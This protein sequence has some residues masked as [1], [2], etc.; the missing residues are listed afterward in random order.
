M[1]IAEPD[2]ARFSNAVLEIIVETEA[3]F[4]RHPETS[5]SYLSDRLRLRGWKN[6]GS[7]LQLASWLE[8]LGFTIVRVPEKKNPSYTLKTLVTI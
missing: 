2:K 3:T 4:P 8:D 6:L 5:L 7:T 1:F